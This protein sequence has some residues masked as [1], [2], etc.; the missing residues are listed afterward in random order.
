MMSDD[1][2]DDNVTRLKTKFKKQDGDHPFLKVVHYDGERC[3]HR[4]RW[5]GDAM[6]SNGSRMVNATYLIREGE[7]EIECGLC[8]TRLDPMFVLRIMAS[9]ENS[10]SNARARYIDEM[11][12]LRERSRTKCMNCGKMTEISRR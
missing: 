9:E 8:N 11:K 3:N 4:Y 5:D 7:T 1:G 12:R 6:S 2:D 10:W